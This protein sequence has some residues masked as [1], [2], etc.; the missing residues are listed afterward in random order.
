MDPSAGWRRSLTDQIKY[1]LPV[2]RPVFK[3]PPQHHAQHGQAFHVQI[4]TRMFLKQDRAIRREFII[5]IIEQHQQIQFW[6]GGEPD[7]QI[8]AHRCVTGDASQCHACLFK[9]RQAPGKGLADGLLR[10]VSEATRKR[11]GVL[12]VVIFNPI[13]AKD[14]FHLGT[15]Q[16]IFA[17]ND[18]NGMDGASVSFVQHAFSG[19]PVGIP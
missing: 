3:P 2:V 16:Q 8:T 4:G 9:V 14:G 19:N 10:G 6:Q 15:E 5:L 1:S 7:G 12:E 18:A 17:Q 13:P 11:R